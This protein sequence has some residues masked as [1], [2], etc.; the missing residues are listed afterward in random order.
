MA[1]IA[2]TPGPSMSTP[3]DGSRTLLV[4]DA[5]PRPGSPHI[6]SGVS[7]RTLRLRGGPRSEQR[8]AW[9][10]DVVDNEGCG[11]KSSK[12]CCIYHKPRKFD[13]SSSEESSSDSDSGSSLDGNHQQY[14]SHR[15]RHHQ[16]GRNHRPGPDSPNGMR[17]D[18]QPT[19]HELERNSDR[20]AYE[21][22][23][24][25]KKGKRKDGAS[26]SFIMV[27]TDILTNISDSNELN[28]PC[29]AGQL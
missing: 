12:I 29:Q 19:V 5:A 20:N 25:S 18:N 22:M 8:V 2:T 7:N 23:P 24:G 9:D 10:E 27:L 4:T 1:I 26:S 13:E 6:S 14:H 15:H 11:R 3:S 21:I 28:R 17:H 16:H